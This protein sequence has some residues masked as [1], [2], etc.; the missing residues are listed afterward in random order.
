LVA[1]GRIPF[2]LE[3][4]FSMRPARYE[5]GRRSFSQRHC[6]I[7]VCMAS[8]ELPQIISLIDMTSLIGWIAE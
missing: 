4:R 3:L 7:D 6:T 8:Q 2:S 5:M 1:R